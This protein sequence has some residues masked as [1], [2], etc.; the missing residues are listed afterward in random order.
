MDRVLEI[1]PPRRASARRAKRYVFDS[2]IK[3]IM[4]NTVYL[5]LSKK[6]LKTYV[7]STD[8]I[9]RRFSEHES[10]KVQSTKNRRP[11]VLIY[12]EVFPSLL[13]ARI[14][15]IYLKT[16]RGRRELKI[17]FKKLNLNN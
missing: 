5:L 11:L 7:G 12:K 16:R 17:I 2:F 4:E 8:N 3:I 6:D 9:E 1:S 13:E 10:G 15:E 14:R